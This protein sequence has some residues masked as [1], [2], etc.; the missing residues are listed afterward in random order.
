MNPVFSLDCRLD[1][2][3]IIE[4][5]AGTGKTYNIQNLFLRYIVEMGIE[6][7]QVLVVTFT[8]V[9]AAEL[10]ERLR[11]ILKLAYNYLNDPQGEDFSRLSGFETMLKTIPQAQIRLAHA[12]SCFD[13]AHISTIHGFCQKVLRSNAFECCTFFEP[14]LRENDDDLKREILL[15]YYRENFYQEGVFQDCFIKSALKVEPF[16]ERV[17]TLLSYTEC[18]FENDLGQSFVLGKSVCEYPLNESMDTQSIENTLFLNA[19][20]AVYERLE[21]YKLAHGLL[22]YDDLLKRV[23]T[24]LTDPVKGNH[25]KTALKTQFKVVFIDEFQDTNQIQYEIFKTLHD[26]EHYLIF[27][28]DPKQAIYAFRGGD[29]KTYVRARNEMLSLGAVRQNLSFNFRSDKALVMQLNHFFSEHTF[30]FGLSPNE[31][32]YTCVDTVAEIGEEERPLRCVYLE[33]ENPLSSTLMLER[34]IEDCSYRVHD[35]INSSN[36]TLVDH[37]VRRRIEAKDIAILVFKN[38]TAK[39]M[40]T[41]L[42]QQGINA[43]VFTEENVYKTDD[44]KEFLSILEAILY[45]Q[46]VQKTYHAMLTPHLGYTLEDLGSESACLKKEHV[47]EICMTLNSIWREQTFMSMIMALKHH[48][49]VDLNLASFVD[50]TQKL[51]RFNQLVDLL[52]IAIRERNLSPEHTLEFLS[53]QMTQIGQKKD[54]PMPRESDDEAV[55]VMTYH[56][57]KGLEFPIVILLDLYTRNIQDS[58]LIYK[59]YKFYRNEQHV[60]FISGN[61]KEKEFAKNAA[62]IV[63]LQEDLRLIYVGMTRAKNRCYFYWGNLSKNRSAMYWL[64]ALRD[65]KNLDLIAP[66]KWNGKKKKSSDVVLS[67]LAPYLEKPINTTL[68]ARIDVNETIAFSPSN[69]NHFLIPPQYNNSFTSLTTSH[70]VKDWFLNIK[71]E[72][73]EREEDA[74][75]QIETRD[76]FSVLAGSLTGNAWHEIFEVIDFQKP[77][78]SQLVESILRQHLLNPSPKNQYVEK[79]V[80]MVE[81]VLRKSLNK[82]GLKLNLISSQQR[83]SELEFYFPIREKHSFNDFFKVFET[84]ARSFGVESRSFSDDF[85]DLFHGYFKGFIDLV[86]EYK[87]KFYIIDWKSNTLGKRIENFYPEALRIAMGE[88]WYFLQYLI[89]SVALMKYIRARTQLDFSV[90][91]E[92][93]FGGVFYLFLRGIQ[94]ENE[95]GIFA[96]C[97][98]ME[99]LEKMEAFL[100]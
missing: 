87:G 93:Y 73:D 61:E 40:Q 1:Q 12:L 45:F 25:L 82:N 83:L 43:V 22:T 48:F 38:N 54:E 95:N 75:F 100:S 49:E 90:A 35:L 80:K 50:A 68:R 69:V 2:S 78:D 37:G 67:F 76:I 59:D 30:P 32:D 96:E 81:T 84:Y 99:L 44:A 65:M 88:S 62:Q 3:M 86:F 63:K 5:S 11:R 91:Y 70:Q 64:L 7:D 41:A 79:T 39:Q 21:S 29:I 85:Y 24:F 47:Q 14:E 31:I 15:D 72:N 42:R 94:D 71:K 97:P 18:L 4:A 6:I 28:G 89:Y 34:A 77:V 26:Q 53:R 9:A 36:E 56:L 60:V 66:A 8:N 13:Q 74:F 23:Y 27:V 98:P 46:Q 33:S 92:R 16:F 55:Q 58:S 57:S 20:Q 10:K 52:D 17:Y 19:T 51:T